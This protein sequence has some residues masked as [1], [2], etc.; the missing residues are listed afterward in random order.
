MKQESDLFPGEEG[1]L[2]GRIPE[3]DRL[4]QFD[5]YVNQL[6]SS[7]KVMQNVWR[8]GESSLLACTLNSTKN[9]RSELYLVI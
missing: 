3:N 1:Q 2:V 4:L 6:A 7:K 9:C 5:G 8:K